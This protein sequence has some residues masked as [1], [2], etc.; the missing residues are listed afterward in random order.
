M[1][2]PN[3]EEIIHSLPAVQTVYRVKGSCL[4]SLPLAP[5]NFSYSLSRCSFPL[6]PIPP[7]SAGSAKGQGEFDVWAGCAGESLLTDR[8]AFVRACGWQRVILLPG[9]Q[10][11]GLWCRLGGRPQKSIICLADLLGANGSCLNFAQNQSQVFC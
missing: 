10:L 6:P 2:A 4:A 8:L 5:V 9:P 3:W 11:K 7:R 1:T